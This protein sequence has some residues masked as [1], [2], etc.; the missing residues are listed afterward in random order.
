[1]IRKAMKENIDPGIDREQWH[2]I[3]VAELAELLKNWKK[4]ERNEIFINLFLIEKEMTNWITNK[5]YVDISMEDEL[6]QD[7]KKSKTLR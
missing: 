7:D 3:S 1:M 6:W 4:G 2:G 5:D